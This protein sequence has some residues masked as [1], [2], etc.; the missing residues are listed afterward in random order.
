MQKIGKY[1]IVEKIGIGGFGAVFKGRDPFIKRFV[2]VKTCNSDDQLIRD[3]FFREAEIA[4]NL[5]HRNVTT[6]YDF[7]IQDGLPYLIQEYLSGEDLDR[8]IKRQDYLPYPEKLYYLLQI[9]RGLAYAHSEGVIHRDIKPGN[10]RILED[11]TAKIMDFGIAKL[12]QQETNLTQ[13]GMTLGTAAYLAP[14]QIRGEPVDLRTDIFSFGVLAYELLA[15]ERPFK[16]KQISV[17]LH[18]ILD[19]QPEPLTAKWPAAPA[20]V[21]ELI[22]RCLRKDRSQRFADGGE[23]LRAI[24]VLQSQGRSARQ[25]SEDIPTVRLQESAPAAVTVT[26]PPGAR[27]TLEDIEFYLHGRD[28]E[29]A[30]PTATEA[31]QQPRNAKPR[32]NLLLLGA[33]ALAAVLAVAGGW[34][35]GARGSDT[36]D[37]RVAAGERPSDLSDSSDLPESSDL[38]DSPDSQTPE[39]PPVAPPEETPPPPASKPEPQVGTLVLQAAG[40]TEYLTA[41][42]GGKTYP[43]HRGWRLELTPRD[44]DVSFRLALP[45][46]SRQASVRAEV[47]A[48]NTTSVE[49]PIARPGALSV[50]PFPTKPRGEVWRDGESLGPSPITRSLVEP[51]RYNIEIRPI[52]D[53]GETV[54]W[55]GEILSGQETVL[56]FDLENDTVRASS[57]PL[58]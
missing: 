20:E 47:S 45:G 42:I 12:T 56:S 39:D 16:G 5:H 9:A 3:R 49:S 43:L 44:Y 58:A 35:L 28:E 54:E 25:V 46:Y 24:E 8:K 6:V 10:I 27:P 23:L 57:K 52:G 32:S 13:T 18:Q 36:E 17:V 11:G 50:R 31:L 40:W 33:I 55:Q 14:E 48:G 41:E 4:G 53:D 26:P 34:W 21:L 51:G 15:Y 29:P 38:S 7:G 37:A 30:E 2:A 1:E 22:D 19:Q